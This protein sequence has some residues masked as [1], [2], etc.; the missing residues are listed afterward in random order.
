MNRRDKRL[1]DAVTDGMATLDGI[2][3][4]NASIVVWEGPQCTFPLLFLFPPLTTDANPISD[5]A[6]TSCIRCGT[7]ANGE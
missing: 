1:S 5:H 7:L 3:Q 4:Y 6:E 2:D